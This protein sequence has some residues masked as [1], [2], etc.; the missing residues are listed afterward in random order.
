[1]NGSLAVASLRRWWLFS[2]E[3]RDDI[4]LVFALRNSHLH[5]PDGFTKG[6]LQAP[7]N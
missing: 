5:L 2:G 1:M 6:V 3:V 7:Y 4:G